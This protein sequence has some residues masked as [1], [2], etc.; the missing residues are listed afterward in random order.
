MVENKVLRF[1]SEFASFVC[2]HTQKYSHSSG[3]YQ[4]LHKHS[5]S[6]PMLYC[7]WPGR[8]GTTFHLHL[9]Q[10]SDQ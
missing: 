6:L 4:G 10:L 5:P 3:S 1:S 9:S 8:L 2:S 7:L